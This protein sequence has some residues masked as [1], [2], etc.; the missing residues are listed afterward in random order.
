MAA[1]EKTL[2]DPRLRAVAER[3]GQGQPL[4][5][6]DL[7]G[8]TLGGADLESDRPLDFSGGD[9]RGATFA[10][11]DL[12]GARFGN[13]LLNGAS[14]HR[15]TLAG[16]DFSGCSGR[17]AV[18]TDV[19]LAYANFAE[20]DLCG[21]LFF[22][23]NMADIS[24]KG[25]SL[26]GSEVDAIRLSLNGG[27]VVSL[28]RRGLRRCVLAQLR[29]QDPRL[30]LGRLSQGRAAPR[31]RELRVPVLADRRGRGGRRL[32]GAHRGGG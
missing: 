13:A 29:R 22:D 24:F 31:P 17:G 10:N 27:T 19:N 12:T 7:S 4:G 8:L 26:D 15:V 21:A 11:V 2:D 5:D 23:A 9:L 32:G 3:I 18:F 1:P 25:A 14:F 20:S 30:E 28:H 6:L 16:A